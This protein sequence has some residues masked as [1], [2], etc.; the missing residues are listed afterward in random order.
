MISLLVATI[1]R[2]VELERFLA[3]LDTQT[4][5]NFEV[6]VIDQNP[7]DRLVPVLCRHAGLAISHLRSGRG[8]SKARNVG[9]RA[10]KGEII[11]IPDDD[12]WYPPQLLSTVAAWFASRSQ[13]DLLLGITRNADGVAMVPRFAP[14]SGPC[15]GGNVLRP[16]I[17]DNVVLG[18][19]C[20]LLGGIHLGDGVTVGANAVVLESVPAN[21]TVAGIPARV[22][23]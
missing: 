1:N 6:I 9:L 11:A 13:T 8:L 10:T 5:R 3:S 22:I 12:C 17:G 15:D 21:A 14:R 2:T 18:A 16:T 19:G 23:S 7:D 20:K 4:Y